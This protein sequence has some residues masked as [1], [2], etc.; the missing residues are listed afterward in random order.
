MMPNAWIQYGRSLA[1]ATAADAPLDAQALGSGPQSL[2][3]ART[4]SPPPDRASRGAPVDAVTLLFQALD[5][6]GVRTLRSRYAPPPRRLSRLTAWT[7]RADATAHSYAAQDGVITKEELSE[8]L[9]SSRASSPATTPRANY[10]ARTPEQPPSGYA[11]PAAAP[12]PRPR[13]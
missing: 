13:P 8:A 4:L 7:T 1:L 3:P 12:R 6:D 10:R 5:S 9:T 11:A 2:S